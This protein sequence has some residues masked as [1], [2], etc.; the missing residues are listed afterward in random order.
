[1]IHSQGENTMGDDVA[2]EAVEIGCAAIEH[3]KRQMELISRG[4][5]SD[6]SGQRA[7]KLVFLKLDEARLWLSEVAR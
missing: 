3:T 5:P 7:M 1:M 6:H 2:R 4:L